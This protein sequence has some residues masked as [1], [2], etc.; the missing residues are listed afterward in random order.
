MNENLV[1]L[2]ANVTRLFRKHFAERTRHV[3]GTGQQWTALSVIAHRPGIT[4][5]M[6]A[7]RLEVEPIT[8]CRMVDR[9]EQAGLV[10]RRRD[11]ADRRV[12]QLFTTREAEPVARILQAEG[13]ELLA[14]ATKGFSTEELTTLLALLGRAR[15]NL[16]ALELPTEK[17]ETRKER[18]NG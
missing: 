3:G 5:G 16:S 4:Q 2:T 14:Q 15:D 8:A 7:E 12:W 13:L 9:M 11:P 17:F 18:Q 1:A 10:E 6:L